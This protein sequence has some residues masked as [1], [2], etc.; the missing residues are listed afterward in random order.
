MYKRVFDPHYYP[1]LMTK[2]SFCPIIFKGCNSR[3]RAIIFKSWYYNSPSEALDG[4]KLT[5]QDYIYH[6]FPGRLYFVINSPVYTRLKR[7][8][9]VF[10][11]GAKCSMFSSQLGAYICFIYCKSMHA[12]L[13]LNNSVDN[14]NVWMINSLSV[15][16]YIRN[17]HVVSLGLVLE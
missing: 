12:A 2:F 17:K 4:I 1:H 15:I 3:A 11:W 7:R 9:I 6:L 8:G 5:E 14:N 10:S 16:W 13:Y